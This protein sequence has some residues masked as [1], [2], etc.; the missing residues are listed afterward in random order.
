MTSN[1]KIA[2]VSASL[3]LGG[4]ERFASLL[5]FMLDNLGYEVHNIIIVDKV[6][7]AYKG[8]LVNLGLLFSEQNKL[9]KKH[10][11]SQFIKK[12]L[13]ENH[14]NTIIDNRSRPNF[15]RE[16]F[17]KQLYKNKKVFFMV[18]SSNLGMYLP[19]LKALAH[20]IYERET[21]LISVSKAISQKIK[22]K[23]DLKN[24]VTIYNPVNI[25]TSIG[26]KP[27]NLP[28]QY[29]LFFGRFEEEIKNFSLLIEAYKQSQVAQHDFYL[30]LIG[31][32]KSK[33][34]IENK[35][36]EVKLENYIHLLPFQTEVVAYIQYAHATV[37]TS[38]FEGFPMS[39]IE[40][41]AAG[42]PIISVDCETGP[43]E[44]VINEYN[45]LLVE[46]HNPLALANA[47]NRFVTDENLHENCKKNAQK[48]IEHLSLERISL[49]WKKILS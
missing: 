2:I 46:N 25:A 32:G 12:Y 16:V 43:N 18:H 37:L 6:D 4:A 20:Y 41:L 24:V 36:K 13:R 9:V 30:I 3:G 22:A 17:T 19:N 45:G 28:N 8:S 38:K 44:I 39:L 31:D 15:I 42:T 5:S 21:T 26:I 27:K 40:S 29:F 10:K 48:S 23:L 1:N 47:L 11:K 14:I 35:I 33:A 7:Y 49:E 34:F